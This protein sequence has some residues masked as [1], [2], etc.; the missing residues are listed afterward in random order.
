MDISALR[1]VWPKHLAMYSEGGGGGGAD[2]RKRWE[3]NMRKWAGLEFA[4]SQRVVENREEWSK[5]V[6]KLSVVPQ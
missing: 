1:Q 5:L 6:K 2:R 4:K 3:D